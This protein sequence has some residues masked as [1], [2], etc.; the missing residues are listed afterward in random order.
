LPHQAA[1]IRAGVDASEL[2]RGTVT[3]LFTDVEGSTRLLKQLRHGYADLLADHQRLVR[4]AVTGHGGREIDTQGEAFFAAFSR[5]KDA[6][7]AA[8]AAQHAHAAHAWPEGAEVRVRMALH[9]AEPDVIDERYIGLGVHR[10]ARLCAAG[11]GGQVLLSRSAAGLVDEDE[12]P[13]IGLRDLGEH[14][15][16]DLERPERIYQ[17]VADGLPEE[18]RPLTTVS[19]VARATEVAARPSG[20]VTFLATDIVG[21]MELLRELGRERYADVLELYDELLRGVFA[22]GGGYEIELVGDSFLVAFPRPRD[23]VR[24]AADALIAVS[25]TDWPHGRPPP[26]RVGVHTG[27]VAQRRTR[28]VGLAVIRALRVCEAASPGQ[29]LVSPST[30]NLL[31]EDDLR[32][33]SLCEAGMRRV[34]DFDRPVPLYQLEAPGE[35]MGTPRVT[36]LSRRLRRG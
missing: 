5:A 29:A 18:F 17:L 13:G 28:Y 14:R 15:L 22:E 2:P 19:E 24:A 8:L 9:T 33:L 21:S 4:D 27:E 32:G 11:H 30:E 31:D 20:T 23:A 25:S 16:K 3:F 35:G 12:L 1:T 36:R 10:A 26:V 34:K 7:T 6:V